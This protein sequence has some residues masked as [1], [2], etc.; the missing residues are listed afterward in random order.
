VLL[1]LTARTVTSLATVMA[2]TAALVKLYGERHTAAA[3]AVLAVLLWAAM[4]AQ[5]AQVVVRTA[6]QE[7]RVLLPQLTLA[8]AVAAATTTR[9]RPLHGAVMAVQE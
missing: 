2:A 9:T 6:T 1:M 4:V 5:V 8:A 3:A 7:G